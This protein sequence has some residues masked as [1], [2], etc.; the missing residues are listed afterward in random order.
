MASPV[1]SL[2]WLFYDETQNQLEMFGT[3]SESVAC[4]SRH[5]QRESDK[6]LQVS[7]KVS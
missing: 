7:H 1:V 5:F 6:K 2:I 3:S 4:R